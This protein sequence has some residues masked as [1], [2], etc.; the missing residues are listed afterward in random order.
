MVM[1]DE[2]LLRMHLM[3]LWKHCRFYTEVTQGYPARL[4]SESPT[5]NNSIHI[6]CKQGCKFT[7][8]Y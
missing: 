3:F 5:T 7:F 2:K 6:S 4:F 1:R 8:K